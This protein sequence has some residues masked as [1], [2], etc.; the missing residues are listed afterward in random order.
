M[1]P[2]IGALLLSLIL[3]GSGGL[4]SAAAQ[5]IG[6]ADAID[7]LAKAC[8]ADIQTHCKGVRLGGGQ[9]RNCLLKNQAK[10]SARCRTGYAEAFQLLEKRFAAQASAPRTCEADARQYCNGVKLGDGSYLDCMVQ[11]GRVVSAQC[12]KALTDAGWK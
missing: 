12:N 2:R 9:V 11:A 8:G 7:R 5:T 4:W 1:Q 3:I 10:L 6:Y